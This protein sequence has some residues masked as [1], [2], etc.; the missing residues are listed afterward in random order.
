VARLQAHYPGLITYESRQSADVCLDAATL[1]RKFGDKDLTALAPLRER[2]VWADLSGTAVTDRS[3]SEIGA[4]KNLRV[5]KLES[6]A[7]TDTG[8]LAFAP[9]TRLESLNLYNTSTSSQA[10]ASF[11]RLKA[12]RRIYVASTK[13]SADAPCPAS[14]RGKLVFASAAAPNL[15]PTGPTSQ[16]R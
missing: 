7:I 11:M 5:L 15:A 3:A 10:M 1:G 2:V 8:V 6:T 9:L 4:M 13:I 14:L 16:N 12:I